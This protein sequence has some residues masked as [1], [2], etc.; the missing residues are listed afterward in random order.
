MLKKLSMSVENKN[1]L[2][3]I[4]RNL[5]IITVGVGV[6]SGYNPGALQFIAGTNSR[7]FEASDFSNLNEITA[8][9]VGVIESSSTGSLEGKC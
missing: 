8:G 1:C 7:V 9:L 2:L 3:S 4:F 5:G 6:G